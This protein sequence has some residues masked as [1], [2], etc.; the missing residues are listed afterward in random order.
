MAGLKGN[1]KKGNDGKFVANPVNKPT[2]SLKSQTRT[3]RQATLQGSAGRR[4]TI[5]PHV[6][7][8]DTKQAYLFG[9]CSALAHELATRLPN[10]KITLI[11]KTET[12]PDGPPATADEALNLNPDW[13]WGT[14]HAVATD[15]NGIAYDINGAAPT[16]AKVSSVSGYSGQRT[17]LINLTPA[18]YRELQARLEKQGIPDH[19]PA[20]NYEVAA[21]VAETCSREY[22]FPL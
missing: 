4:H 17:T 8:D 11:V 5:N 20:Q 13:Y 9:Q 22:E 15:N 3:I 21:V 1:Q 12:F 10:G 2:R 6:I 19:I 18:Q 7:N 14:S 16:A